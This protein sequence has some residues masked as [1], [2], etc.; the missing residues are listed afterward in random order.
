M[1]VLKAATIGLAYGFVI[2]TLSMAIFIGMNEVTRQLI[3][4]V[5]ASICY[6][7]S[8]LVFGIKT[9]KPILISCLHYII[10][11]LVTGVNIFLFYQEYLGT[12]ILYFTA[13]YV[14]IYLFSWYYDRIT[15]GKLN[16]ALK[17]NSS[18][19]DF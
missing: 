8:S 6:G 19:E 11:L 2:T 9:V 7:M 10:C 3:A 12:V 13:I 5:I 17:R 14:M 15:I 18:E 1:K 16:E 4:W